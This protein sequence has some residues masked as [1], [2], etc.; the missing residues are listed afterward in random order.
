MKADRI[1][2]VGGVLGLLLI[3]VLMGASQVV[4]ANDTG[5]QQSPRSFAPGLLLSAASHD[6]IETA[7]EAA[8]SPATSND[9]ESIDETSPAIPDTDA[10]EETDSGE[11]GIDVQDMNVDTGTG[12]G[13]PVSP[14]D[15]ATSGE[16]GEA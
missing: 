9:R 3:S 10:V 1:W 16:A 12:T 5:I 13:N 14:T 7:D 15:P 11:T 8:P 6:D 2:T 4:R